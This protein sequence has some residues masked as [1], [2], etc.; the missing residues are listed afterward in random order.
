MVFL[1]FVCCYFCFFFFFFSSRRRHTRFDCDWSSDVCSSDL[2]ICILRFASPSRSRICSTHSSGCRGFGFGF[3]IDNA[4]GFIENVI[5]KVADGI[6]D[7]FVNCCR[8][9]AFFSLFGEKLKQTESQTLVSARYL[10]RQGRYSL[11]GVSVRARWPLNVLVYHR[12]VSRHFNKTSVL[13]FLQPLP[14]SHL[15]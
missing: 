14:S 9:G 11:E 3:L 8:A 13:F 5:R 12:L 6:P 7:R 15:D 10:E 1:L 2:Q 4:D